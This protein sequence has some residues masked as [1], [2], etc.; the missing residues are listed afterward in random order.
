[1][2]LS[3]WTCCY[4]MLPLLHRLPKE[5]ISFVLRNGIHVRN[6]VIELIYRKTTGTPRF[7]PRSGTPL[8]KPRFAFIV[9]TKIDKRATAR[10]RMRRVMSESVRHLL[11][12]TGP[13]DGIFIAKKNFADLP[14]IEVEELVAPL[15]SKAGFLVHSSV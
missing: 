15:L 5:E 12:K 13:V 9:S 8:A 1:M 3:N 2:L 11:P 6:D 14:Q 4:T 7:V 10:N